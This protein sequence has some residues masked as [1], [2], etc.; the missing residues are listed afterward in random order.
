MSSGRGLNVSG[1]THQRTQRRT[2]TGFL[3]KPFPLPFRQTRSKSYLFKMEE[4]LP[5]FR[6]TNKKSN[7]ILELKKG[8]PVEWQE[9]DLKYFDFEDFYNYTLERSTI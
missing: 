9:E 1:R 2:D 4:P 3:V 6:E 8:L 5:V 7:E